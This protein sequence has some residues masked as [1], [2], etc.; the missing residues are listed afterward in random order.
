MS[1]GDVFR[2]GLFAGDLL[3]E[4]IVRSADWLALDDEEL[5]GLEASFRALFERFPVA[6]SPNESQTEDDLIWPVFRLLGWTVWRGGSQ[7]WRMTSASRRRSM[8]AG[9]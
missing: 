8:R 9:S 6:H 4:A 7:P 2:G 1:I 3:T 5:D